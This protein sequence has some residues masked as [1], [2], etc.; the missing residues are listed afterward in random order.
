MQK[1]PDSKFSTFSFITSPLGSLWL[2]VCQNISRLESL[3]AE[4]NCQSF[5][6]TVESLIETFDADQNSLHNIKLF[7]QIQGILIAM[8]RS[9]YL[10]WT[11]ISRQYQ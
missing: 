3:I 6:E 9:D 4:E 7:Q 8:A 2:D 11:E 10:D 5:L 1:K